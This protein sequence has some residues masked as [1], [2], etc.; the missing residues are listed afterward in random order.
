MG[1]RSHLGPVTADDVTRT[2]QHGKRAAPSRVR[3][4][5]LSGRGGLPIG[6]A[7]AGSLTTRSLIARAGALIA[8]AVL[9][10]IFVIARVAALDSLTALFF[11]LLIALLVAALTLITAI[12]A[13]APTL[14]TALVAALR[15]V[16]RHFRCSC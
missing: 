10:L 2:V 15:F 6:S 7:I 5:S 16:I 3:P 8:P 14:A 9:S 11:G 4:F 1:V 12:L 13:T